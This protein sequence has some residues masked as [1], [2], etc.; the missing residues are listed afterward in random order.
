MRCMHS[1]CDSTSMIDCRLN[2]RSMAELVPRLFPGAFSVRKA[3]ECSMTLISVPCPDFSHVLYHVLDD[4][5]FGQRRLK[6]NV[7]QQRQNDQRRKVVEVMSVLGH[8]QP[9]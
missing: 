2:H 7:G 9:I 3:E 8:P 1:S 5:A 4:H 6:I